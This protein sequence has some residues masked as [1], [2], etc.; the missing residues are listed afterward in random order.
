MNLYNLLRPLI[1]RGD[2]QNVESVNN[3]SH[4]VKS[5]IELEKSKYSKDRI[6][7]YYYDSLSR[8]FN[9]VSGE[10]DI[11]SVL[12]IGCATGDVVSKMATK[13]PKTSFLAIDIMEE[14]IIDAKKTYL[15]IENLH[16]QTKDFLSENIE[17]KYDLITCLQTLE[18]IEDLL[19]DDFLRKIFKLAHQAVILSVPREPI[20]SLANICRFKYLSRFGNSPHH[21]QHWRKTTFE[22]LIAK[23]ARESWTKFE[24][25]TLNPIKL[26]TIVL[27]I[28][29]R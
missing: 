9:L 17:S 8:L 4:L 22:N 10:R 23:I 26:W 18:H 5:A 15:K 3:I 16:F 6:M 2:I 7:K 21:L 20:W 29:I 28:K 13:A 11:L 27:L 12:D 1:T 19:L 24:I 25:I 14:A